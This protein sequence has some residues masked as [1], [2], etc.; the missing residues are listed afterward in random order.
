MKNL[1]LLPL[2]FL[3]ATRT[4][5]QALPDFITITPQEVKKQTVWLVNPTN[6]PDQL[7][8]FAFDGKTSSEIKAM[9]ASHLR[10]KIIQDGAVVAES[11]GDCK[12]L[13]D[14]NTNYVGLVL[15]FSNYAQ[16]KLAEKTLAAK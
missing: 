16:A 12:G 4:Y 11:V 1:I 13:F 10:A 6:A 9:V 8:A 15:T 2:F 3:I 14:K 7:V 5:G